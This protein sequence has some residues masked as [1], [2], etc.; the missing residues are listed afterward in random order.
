MRRR[1]CS[2]GTWGSANSGAEGG[3]SRS[4][5]DVDGLPVAEGDPGGWRWE[6]T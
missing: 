3:E 2:R 4:K 1:H 6:W 5:V